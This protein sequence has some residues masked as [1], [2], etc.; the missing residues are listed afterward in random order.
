M[1]GCD[2]N[3]TEKRKDALGRS[4]AAALVL[5][6]ACGYGLLSPLTKLAL[7]DGWE[8]TALAAAQNACAA[9]LLWLLVAATP[10]ARMN[11][12][13]GPW[14]QLALLGVTGMGGT[15]VFLNLAIDRLGPSVA[16]VLLFQFVWMAMLLEAVADR[17]VPSFK[18]VLAMLAV[19]AGTPLAAGGAFVPHVAGKWNGA[20]IGFGL[21]SALCYGVFLVG[22]G[23]VRT[24]LHPLSRS[25]FM[26]TASLPALWVWQPPW[27]WFGAGSAKLWAWGALLGSVGQALPAVALNVGVPMIGGTLAALLGAA[28]LPSAVLFS[29]WI[30]GDPVGIAEW[31]GIAL[32]LAGMAIAHTGAGDSR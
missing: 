5:A 15:T 24:A 21:L 10:K 1:N 11:P 19:W 7:D 4:G 23:R 22:I 29:W 8:P 20:G 31:C 13:R 2:R 12:F 32:I 28:E 14:V 9:V 3:V 25:A 16:V 30:A 17:R 6:G 27:A 18:R 26:V